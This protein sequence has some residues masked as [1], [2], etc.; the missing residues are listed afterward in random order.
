MTG[1]L[2][3]LGGAGGEPWG[4]GRGR[5]GVSSYFASEHQAHRHCHL[6]SGFTR[7]FLGGPSNFSEPVASDVK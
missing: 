1:G 7:S 3:A 2:R 6:A 4:R 5:V